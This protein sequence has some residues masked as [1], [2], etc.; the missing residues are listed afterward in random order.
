VRDLNINFDNSGDKIIL[1]LD[2]ILDRTTA[3]RLEVELN[4]HIDRDHKFI[5]LDFTQVSYLSS[6]GLR[7]L[8]AATKKHHAKHADGGK[9]VIFSLNDEM[10]E[11]IHHAGFDKV[12]R[13][14]EG[15]REALQVH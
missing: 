9:F 3:I 13:I 15:E 7:V 10:K 8:L 12:F 6:A 1:R 14:C 4:Q 2:G 5:L 11:I